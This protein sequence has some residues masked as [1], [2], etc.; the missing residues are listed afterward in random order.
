MGY[1]DGSLASKHQT[2]SFYLAVYG[3]RRNVIEQ[4]ED[5]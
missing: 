3:M 4:K 2:G 5:I 1:S